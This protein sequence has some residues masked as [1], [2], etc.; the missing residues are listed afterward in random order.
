MGNISATLNRDGVFLLHKDAE[1]ELVK[2]Q[3]SWTM[4][5]FEN[6]WDK[7]FK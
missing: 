3:M 7:T 2:T 4:N 5:D 1:G 6:I